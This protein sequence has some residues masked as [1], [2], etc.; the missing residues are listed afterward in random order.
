MLLTSQY[1]FHYF[2]FLQTGNEIGDRGADSLEEALRG[3]S[4]LTSL[5]LSGEFEFRSL[6][7]AFGFG[8]PPRNLFGCNSPCFLLGLFLQLLTSQIFVLC[9]LFLQTGNCIGDRGARSL[10]EALRV[11]STLTSLDLRGELPD[12]SA[13]LLVSFALFI[14]KNA[15][16]V[17]V[18]RDRRFLMF[19]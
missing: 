16:F 18:T 19:A 2:C 15:Y 9:I 12:R 11:N 4:T 14:S 3:N 1:F 10:A 13:P 8:S 17:R 5:G 7:P 6:R